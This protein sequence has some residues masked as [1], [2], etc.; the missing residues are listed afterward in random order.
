M[1]TQAVSFLKTKYSRDSAHMSSAS[2]PTPLLASEWFDVWRLKHV[3]KAI[4]KLENA[5]MEVFTIY[6]DSHH[7][8]YDKEYKTWIIRH[9]LKDNTS[10]FVDSRRNLNKYLD[11]IDAIDRISIH[12]TVV[13]AV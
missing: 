5:V 1:Q 10:A 9:Y 3:L 6:G 2:A 7:F 12:R 13:S 4:K 11:R 8:N